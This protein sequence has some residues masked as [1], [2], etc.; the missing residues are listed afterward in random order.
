MYNSMHLKDVAF[1]YNNTNAT[2]M[3]VLTKSPSEQQTHNHGIQ[4]NANQYHIT[5]LQK[6]VRHW[7]S[8]KLLT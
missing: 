1:T 4:L 2:S 8:T 3:S 7:G 6:T 5:V